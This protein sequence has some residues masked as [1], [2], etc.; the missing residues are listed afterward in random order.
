MYVRSKSKRCQTKNTKIQIPKKKYSNKVFILYSSPLLQRNDCPSYTL[1]YFFCTRCTRASTCMPQY[2]WQVYP[3]QA[4]P[5]P[6]PHYC[7]P[8]ARPLT[9][10]RARRASAR[11][12]RQPGRHLYFGRR[13]IIRPPLVS[14]GGRAHGA[15][16]TF[17]GAFSPSRSP[18]SLKF[19]AL[20]CFRTRRFP[21][22]ACVAL[23]S[24]SRDN[25]PR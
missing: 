13:R 8:F 3:R 23:L 9:P 7:L 10:L 2:D 14:T 17:T 15:G 24:T 1:H 21:S 25:P 6:P 11:S 5:R 19:Q 22:R 4:P 16:L 18:P 20:F 12:N